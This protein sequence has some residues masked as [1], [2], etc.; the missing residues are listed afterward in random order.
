MIETLASSDL[1]IILGAK[2]TYRRVLG[3]WI[4]EANIVQIDPD[5]W[6]LGK[7][8]ALRLGVVADI[9]ELLEQLTLCADRP[10]PKVRMSERQSGDRGAGRTFSDILTPE[11]VVD[12]LAAHLDSNTLI[13]DDSQSLGYHLKRRY[14]FKSEGTLFGSLASHL[15][16]GLPSSIGVQVARPDQ[17][18]VA[19]LSDASFLLGPQGLWTAAKY[20]LPVVFIIINN[21]GFMS[22]RAEL[23]SVAGVKD[24]S[25]LMSLT[26]PSLA[27]PMMAV[28]FGV[29]AEIAQTRHEF[30]A[31]L[32]R[33]MRRKWPVVIDAQLESSGNEWEGLWYTP[34]RKTP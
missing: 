3:D 1:L 8:H 32:I 23:A 18:V 27:I 17:Q 22:L 34:H 7:N 9:A 28:S 19:L 26:N 24:E 21:R 16:W 25:G 33:A 29:H 30:E 5:A 4:D 14:P 20:S 6:E 10:T 15:G 13:V 12:L 31:A 11:S 2:A